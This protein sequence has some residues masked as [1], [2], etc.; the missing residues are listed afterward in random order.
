MP[1]TDLHADRRAAREESRRRAATAP[2]SCS[3]ASRST[4]PQAARERATRDGATVHLGV[5]RRA[6]SIAGQGTVGLEIAE[7]R[8]RRRRRGRAARRRRA[9]VGHRARA[10]RAAA[11][12]AASSACRRPA[13]PVSVDASA[14]GE[15]QPRGRAS[16]TI[17]DGIAVKRPGEVTFPLVRDLVDDIVEVADEEIVDGDGRCCSSAHKLLVEGAGAVG[18]RR[19]RSAGRIDGSRARRSSVVLSG[20]NIDA[21]ADAGRRAPR[22]DRRRAATSSAARRSSTGPGSLLQLLRLLAEDRINIVDVEHHREGIDVFVTDTEVELT[23]ETRDAA[24]G[25]EVMALLERRGFATE[26]VR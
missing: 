6:A 4:T 8:A 9:A 15:I 18:A 25:R 26:R 13:A 16:S 3:R 24:H 23:V 21:A 20:G 19:A 1:A 14:A 5:R 22:A 11:R 17:A 2:R 12:G 10:A 7:Q